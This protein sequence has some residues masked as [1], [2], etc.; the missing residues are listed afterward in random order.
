MGNLGIRPIPICKG[1][2]DRSQW[3]YRMF[4]GQKVI[5][6]NYAWYI[7]G[8]N[9]GILVDCGGDAKEF[10]KRG[11]PDDH[12][13]TLE[14]GLGKLGVSPEDIKEVVVTH[15]HWDHLWKAPRFSHAKF[16]VQREEYDFALD[17]HP[18]VAGSFDKGL[19]KDL[20]FE[21]VEGDSEIADGVR[22]FLTPGHTPAGQSVAVDTSKG[23][24]VITGFCCTLENFYPPQEVKA[25]GIEIVAPGIHMDVPK[26]YDSV[27]KVKEMADIVIPLHEPKFLEVDR[28]P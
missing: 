22:V 2:R 23:L 12:I 24:A 21:F 1:T 5:G 20:D 25:K 15:M 8:T 16:Y 28:I 6:A 13:Q 10:N 11:V 9:H 18:S 7:E 27:L 17:P 14:E 26:V 3:L 19:F 4:Y